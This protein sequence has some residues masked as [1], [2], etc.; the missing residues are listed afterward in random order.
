MTN[1]T[2]IQRLILR[3]AAVSTALGLVLSGAALAA[4]HN[5]KMATSWGGGPVMEI[6]VDAFVE[7]VEF[8]TEGRIEIKVFPSGQLTKGLEVRS[9]V[10]KGVAEAGHTWM[11]YD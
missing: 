6:G 8:L 3:G 4:E 2:M 1:K 5:W 7:K 10:A 9:A 11:G